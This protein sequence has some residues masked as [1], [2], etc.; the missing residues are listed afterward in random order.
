[1]ASAVLN[2]RLEIKNNSSKENGVEF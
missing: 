1:L 2:S